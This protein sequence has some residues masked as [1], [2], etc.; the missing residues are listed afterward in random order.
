MNNPE[1]RNVRPIDIDFAD[2]YAVVVTFDGD[3]WKVRGL[4]GDLQNITWQRI[5]CGMQEPSAVQIK[6]GKIFVFGRNGITKVTPGKK[7]LVYENHSSDFWQSADTRDF[8]HSLSVDHKGHFYFSKGGQ[9][10]DYPSKH[11]GRILKIDDGKK[12]KVFASGLRNTYLTTR[13][14]TDEIYA[15]DQQGH[16][17]PATPIHRIMEGGYYGF[18]PAAPWNVPEPKITPP[19]CWIPHTVAGS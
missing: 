16:W 11:S 3:L 18:Q 10:N 17:I 12:V 13:P 8:A 15:S 19:L 9:Q 14:G 1:R 2:G 5:A 4:Q 7:G 6:D